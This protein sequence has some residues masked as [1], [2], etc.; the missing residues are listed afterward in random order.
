MNSELMI[1]KQSTLNRLFARFKKP[2]TSLEENI[3]LYNFLK[4]RYY[5]EK[6]FL[7]IIPIRVLGQE[8]LDKITGLDISREDYIKSLKGIEEL[9]N[10]KELYCRLGVVFD[11]ES[12]CEALRSEKLQAKRLSIKSPEQLKGYD[13]TKLP[14]DVE[15]V[16]Y[17]INRKY[18]IIN[19]EIL[20]KKEDEKKNILPTISTDIT[21]LSYE[22]SLIE[23]ERQ[24][25]YEFFI[26]MREKINNG[27][28]TVEDIKQLVGIA[29]SKDEKKSWELETEEKARVQ[30]ETL[31][32]AQ[33]FEE[34]ESK[35]DISKV[36]SEGQSILE[37][38]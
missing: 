38:K 5:E 22:D 23:P 28:L 37:E 20:E 29:F 7:G 8:Q 11:Y 21:T 35:K 2:K 9:H 27:E 16:G 32:I 36:Q 17:D 18:D 30:N 1:K 3:E 10:L 4:E 31:E 25:E 33:E 34:Q 19:G 6:K 12:V 13:L 26:G 15:I 14:L 24:E